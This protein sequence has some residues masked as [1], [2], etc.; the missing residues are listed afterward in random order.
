MSFIALKTG[1]NIYFKP[2]LNFLRSILYNPAQ[3]T[4]NQL[5]QIVCSKPWLTWKKNPSTSCL[6]KANEQ[7]KGIDKKDDKMIRILEIL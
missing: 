5:A 4:T 7:C 2:N 6:E 1:K 3:E